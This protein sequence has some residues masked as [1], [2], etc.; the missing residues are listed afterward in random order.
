MAP[1]RRQGSQSVSAACRGPLTLRRY[2]S[3]MEKIDLEAEMQ[4]LSRVA[5]AERAAAVEELVDQLENRLADVDAGEDLKES[6]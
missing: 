4:R 3:S 5:A 2:N 6:D 1:R